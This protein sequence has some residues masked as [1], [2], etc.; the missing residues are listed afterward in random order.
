LEPTIHVNQDIVQIR[1]YLENFLQS[2]ELLLYQI[3]I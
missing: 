1:S 2:L 3:I